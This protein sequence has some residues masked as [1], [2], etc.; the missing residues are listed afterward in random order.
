M[1]LT[2]A[3]YSGLY[4]LLWPFSYP[5]LRWIRGRDEDYMRARFIPPSLPEKKKKRSWIH[6]V[7]VGETNVALTLARDITEAKE[8]WEVVISTSTTTGLE[9]LRRKAS[10]PSFLS[11]WDWASVVRRFG[12]RI[13][14]DKLIIVETELWPALIRETKRFGVSVYVVNARI[15]DKAYK[16]YQWIKGFLKRD[17][18]PF[19]DLILCQ[20]ELA[21]ERFVSLGAERVKV[22]GNVKFDLYIEERP[23]GRLEDVVK[24]RFVVVLGSTHP[25]EEEALAKSLR[26]SREDIFLIVAPRHPERAGEVKKEVAKAGWCAVLLSELEDGL[27]GD[28]VIIDRI[29][30][31][32]QVY[33]LADVVFI[34]GSLV[35]KGGQNPLEAAYW[36]KP[37]IFGPHMENF[38]EIASTLLSHRAA[39]QIRTPEEI[40]EY[41]SKDLSD[42]GQSAKAV[43]SQNRGAIKRIVEEVFG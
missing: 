4:P 5:Y 13:R 27:S 14:P 22:C 40:K 36:A 39:V 8:D 2:Y 21:K 7:S 3:L 32:A 33:R 37:V 38:R 31:L 20:D 26:G 17:V 43:L 29:G 6:A 25:G 18:F 19:V 24:R 15:S 42:V 16:R 41:L 1:S 28:A 9:N 34:G 11:P 30:V 23:L 12:E 35:P 10:F